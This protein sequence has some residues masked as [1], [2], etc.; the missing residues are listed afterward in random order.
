VRHLPI[1]VITRSTRVPLWALGFGIGLLAEIFITRLFNLNGIVI[2][3]SLLLTGQ[4][5]ITLVWMLYAW[6]D[7]ESAQRHRSPE[8]YL[9]P[10]KSFTA[11]LPARHEEEV[12]GDTIR[13]IARINYPND[14]KELLVLCRLDDLGTIYEAT[15]AINELPDHNIRLI[16]FDDHPINKPHS[17]NIGLS[18]AGHEVVTIFDAEDQPHPDLYQI[19]NTVMI[20]EKADVVQSG[21]QLMNYRS[22]WYSA[23]N[24]MEYFLWFKSGLRFFLKIGNVTPLGGNTVFFKKT[25][26]LGV[27]GWDENC[28]TEDA[29]IGIRLIAAGAKPMVIYDEQHATQEETPTSVAGFIKQRTRWNQGFLQIFLNKDE[30]KNLPQIRQKLVTLYILLSPMY[31]AL[32]LLYAPFAVWAAFTHKLPVTVALISFVPLYLFVL[33]ILVYVVGLYEFTRAY[34]LKYPV[35]MPFKIL[36]TFYPYQSLLMVSSFRAVYRMVFSENGWE[37]TL[38]ANDHRE[39]KV[40]V[41]YA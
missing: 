39:A 16:T 29:D 36:L 18:E 14:L 31:Q 27:G 35:W 3:I 21:V 23:L 9:P 24:V 6:E 12:I 19:I 28:L 5:I 10:R 25:Q 17:L 15:A 2:L 33:Q 4:G 30:W 38:H 8:E 22:N 41:A 26:L 7:P 11:L 40:Q 34:G 37:K 1:R 20:R 32:M 13:A